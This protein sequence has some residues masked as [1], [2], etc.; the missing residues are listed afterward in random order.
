MVFTWFQTTRPVK[1]FL[2]VEG[3]GVDSK[4]QGK[5][6]EIQENPGKSTKVGGKPLRQVLWKTLLNFRGEGMVPAGRSE[7][8][9]LGRLI[10]W[11][12]AWLVCCIVVPSE[13][14]RNFM[15][16]WHM[17]TKLSNLTKFCA[18][19]YIYFRVLYFQLPHVS[20]DHWSLG[21]G[22]PVQL[23][24]EPIIAG[25]LGWKGGGSLGFLLFSA[26]LE[27]SRVK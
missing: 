14:S 9:G 10:G 3:E 20:D 21:S 1:H 4:W 8:R 24:S 13:I 19:S 2:Q 5:H 17:S 18:L 15:T 11:V 16:I 25:H 27:R 6:R 7:G 22:T 12:L 26:P 23:G